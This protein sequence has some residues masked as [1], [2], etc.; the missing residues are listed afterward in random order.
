MNKVNKGGK[1]P[2]SE[3]NAATSSDFAFEEQEMNLLSLSPEIQADFKKRN[4]AARW[5]NSKNYMAN[6]NFHKSGWRAYRVP[7]EIRGDRGSLDFNFGMSPEGYIIRNDLLLAFKP[8]ELQE[9]HRA[10]IQARTASQN[11]SN[12]SRAEEIRE[13]AKLAGVSVKVHEGYDEN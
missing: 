3:K 12:S 13:S 10:R 8:A 9:K 4:L 2:L 5:V 6:G 1:T 7:E 11:G